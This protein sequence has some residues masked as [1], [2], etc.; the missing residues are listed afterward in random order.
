[1]REWSIVK[2]FTVVMTF[3]IFLK[4]SETIGKFNPLHDD[5]IQKQFRGQT[6]YIYLVMY[7]KYNIF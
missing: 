3:I 6:I 2:G 4:F 7:Y 1:M 5:I